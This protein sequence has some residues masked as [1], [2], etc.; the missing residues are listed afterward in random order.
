M[1]G[2]RGKERDVKEKERMKE[3]RRE[4][5]DPTRMVCGWWMLGDIR[6]KWPGMLGRCA[7]TEWMSREFAG[8]GK[9][10]HLIMS[11]SGQD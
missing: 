8:D 7:K 1:R 11:G 2:G 6:R 4:D 3:G 10:V 5:N 9:D